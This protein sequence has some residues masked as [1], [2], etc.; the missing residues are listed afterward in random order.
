MV[1][2]KLLTKQ[3]VKVYWKFLQTLAMMHYCKEEV[4][5]TW[6]T[7][8][9]PRKSRPRT[10]S[11]DWGQLF[12]LPWLPLGNSDIPLVFIVEFFAK[13]SSNWSMYS[14]KTR[15]NGS[16]FT[17]MI[18]TVSFD[19]THAAIWQKKFEFWNW[20]YVIARTTDAQRGNSLHCTAENSLPLPNC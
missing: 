7:G 13:N 6:I 9:N 12:M 3:I 16:K 4:K 1:C 15:S 10:E 11:E 8:Q 20:W 14:T 5:V 2:K 18:I 17:V 19:E